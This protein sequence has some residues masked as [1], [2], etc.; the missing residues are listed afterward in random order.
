MDQELHLGVG[1]ARNPPSDYKV[2]DWRRSKNSSI[3]AWQRQPAPNSMDFLTQTHFRSSFRIS[4]AAF[5]PDIPFNPVPGCE[6]E[7]H[8][9][10]PWI[11]VRYWA[12]SKTAR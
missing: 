1:D 5:A 2:V 4:L 9:Y 8:K 12:Q 3:R 7:P 6:P 11:G 10:K